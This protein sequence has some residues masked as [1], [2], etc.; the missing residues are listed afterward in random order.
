MI[1]AALVFSMSCAQQSED[2]SKKEGTVTMTQQPFGDVEGKPVELY[3]FTNANGMEVGIMTYGGIIVSIKTPDKN[4]QTADV[5]LGFNS[6]EGYLKGHPYFGALVGRY[7][8]RIAKGK[9]TLDGQEYTL[10]INNDPNALHGGLKGFDKKVWDAQ[11]IEQDGQPAL[12]LTCSSPDGEEG[13]PGNLTCKVIYSLSNDNE[14]KIE[15]FA[16]TDKATPLNLTNHVYFNLAGEG[17]GD[18]LDH[19]VMLK[20]GKF[21]PV[22]ETLIPT[23]EL[24]PVEGTPMD[25][26][27]P[28]R[29]GDRIDA[30][31]E[32][33][34][35]GGGY[36][37]N[38]VLDNQS[39]QL[40]LGGL[41][42]EPTSGRILEFYTTQPG[43]QFY[44][45]NFL[46]GTLVGKA[47][48]AYEKRNGFCL[49]TQ[50][51]PDSPNHPN[52]PSSILK[53]GETYHHVTVYKFST[54]K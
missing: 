18:I 40:A 38:W 17:S 39:G 32:Q 35:F 54:E 47:G 45:G 37:H 14:L 34:K 51:Y 28:T 49:E 7:G 30:D 13:Y 50:H 21:T 5:A 6:L 27:Q 10:A 16:E 48:K 36:D 31:D 44:C 12:E 22:D 15:Y 46:D 53:P 29:I 25:F 2:A 24:R 4:G 52:F 20:A 41:V 9:F 3:T 19:V 11:E 8:N 43:V 23:G 33:I 1:G 42:T 26:T